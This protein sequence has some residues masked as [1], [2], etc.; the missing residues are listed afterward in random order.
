MGGLNFE[1]KNE[2]SPNTRRGLGG[3]VDMVQFMGEAAMLM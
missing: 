1:T 3:P 2:T